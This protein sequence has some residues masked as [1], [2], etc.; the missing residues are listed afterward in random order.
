M[1]GYRAEARPLCVALDGRS[2]GS[3]GNDRTNGTQVPEV[4]DE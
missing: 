3:G 4:V 2:T 1:K